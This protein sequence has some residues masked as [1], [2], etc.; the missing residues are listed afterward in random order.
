VVDGVSFMQITIFT[1]SY[2]QIPLA[3]CAGV[4]VAS[5]QSRVTETVR[6]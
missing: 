6:C 3:A 1:R 4:S 2:L 5:T